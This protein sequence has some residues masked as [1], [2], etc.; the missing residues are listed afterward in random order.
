MALMMFD[1]FLRIWWK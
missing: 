1:L